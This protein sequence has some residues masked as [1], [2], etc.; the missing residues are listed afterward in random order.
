MK[1]PNGQLRSNS[2]QPMLQ[3]VIVI[4]SL[5]CVHVIAT[6]LIVTHQAPLSMGFSRQE[7]WSELPFSSP[8]DLPDPGLELRS[9]ALHV[10]TL[11]SEPPGKIYS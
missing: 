8:G 10:D 9:P 5:N 1:A 6:P 3:F 11:L 4:Q 2:Q 7:Y